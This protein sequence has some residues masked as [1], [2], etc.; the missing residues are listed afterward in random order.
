VYAELHALSNFSFLRGASQPEE[1]IAQ[2][3]ALN[4]SALALTDECTLAGVVRAHVAAKEL[5]LPLIIGTELKCLDKLKLVALATDRASYGAMSRLISKARRATRKGCYA[6][7]RSDL[8]NALA[9]CL[10]IWLPRADK[11]VWQRQEADGRWLRDR[12]AERLW[13]GVELLTGGHD[14]RRL[15][16]LETLGQ[17]LQLPCVAAG[18]VHMHRRSRRALQ[19]VLTAIRIGQ[20]LQAA[21]YALYPNGERSLRSLQRLGELYPAQLLTQTLHIAERCTFKL[22]ELRY[23]YPEEIVPAGETPASHLRA[24]TMQGCA[25]RW[26]AGAPAAVLENIE[27]ELRLIAELNFEPFFLTVHDIVD[28]ARSQKI[29]CQG[30]GSA[31]NS[32][33]CYCL[34]ITEVDPSRMSMLFERFISKERNEPPDIDVDFEHERREEVIQYIYRK[35]GRE[36]AALAATVICYRPRSALRDVGK[37]LGL[38]LAQ[39]D[40]LAQGMQW[41]DGQ[42][43]DPERIRASGFDPDDPVIARLIALTAE[44]LGFPRHLSQHVGGF[45]IARGRLD[46]LVPIENAAMPDRTVIEWDKDDLDALGLLKVDVLALGMLT[47]IRRTFH[48]VNEFGGSSAAAGDLEL[49]SIPSEDQAVYDMICRADTIGVFQIESRAQMS[50][51]PRLKPRNFYDL[52]IEVAIVRP[53]PIQGEM[54]HPYLRRRSGEEEV[55]YPSQEVEAVLKRTLGVP[56]FQE[57]VMQLAIVAAG[58]SPGEAD[59]LRRAMAAWKRKGGLEPFQ[60]QLIDG[61]RER[62][63]SESFA[64]QIF[65]QILGFGEYGFP[66]CVVG[67][68]R[69]V[70]A[71]TGKWVTIDDVISGQARLDNTLACDDKLRLQK[72]K[73]LRVISS[74]VK[75]VRRL[76]T[77]LGHEI[78]ATAE[79]PFMTVTGWLELGKLKVGDHV[80]TARSVPV[81]GHRRWSRH[82]ILVLADLIAEGNL[83]HPSTFYFY[84]TE[85]WHRDDFVEAVE[86]F[87]NTKAVVERHKNCF[88]VR[89]RRIDRKRQIGA[90]TWLRKLGVWGCG[91]RAKR[92]PP[93]V[94]ELRNSNIE[95][96][97][98]RL[99]EGDGGFSVKGGHASYDTAS[100]ILA[101]QVQHLLLRL[102]II[103]RLYRR[104]RAYKG[105]K[106]EHQVITV[107]GDDLR[108]FCCL[109]GRRFLDPKRRRQSK[110]LAAPRNGRMSRDIIPAGVRVAIRSER[111]K[112]KLTW[113]EISRMTG[114]SM[115]EIQGHGVS[116]I[117][118]RRH[119]IACV[120]TALGSVDLSRLACSDIYWD[121][122]VEIEAVGDRE[123]YDLKIEGDHNFLANNFIVHNS[124][125]ASFALLVYTSAWLKHYEPAAFCAAL[126]NSQPMGFYAPAQLVRD[127]RAH[128]VEVRAVDVTISGWDCTLERREDGRPA[129]RL[130]LRLVKHLSQEGAA[131]LLAMRA[132]CNFDGIADMAERAALDRRDLEALAAADALTKLAGHR[133]RAVW[134]VTGVERA[135]PLLPAATAVDEGIPLLRAPREGQDIVADYGSLGL[136]L[137]RHP[138]ALLRDRLQRR[139]VVPTRELWEQPNGKWVKTAGLV[140]TRQRPGSAG[141][142]TFVTMEDETGYVNLIVWN[143]VAVE[144]RAALLESRL[145]EV[146]GKLQRE[147]DVQHV[148][149]QR[150][151]NLSSLLGDLVVGSRNFH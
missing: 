69:V 1:L 33:V 50:M 142:V 129:L 46:E 70:D 123:T 47:A 58:F 82:K 35:Y 143:R 141:G 101:S 133:H 5:G 108:K 97:L 4:Y 105:R 18:D 9:G 44:I 80:A 118:F 27:H 122:V 106:L 34:R 95:L 150:L 139:G 99:W 115:R 55:N 32:T 126:I 29:L 96:L 85:S 68:T 56:I 92:L 147:G 45:V 98:A 81:A 60:H 54:V 42:R 91:A 78:T 25:Y 10:I 90:V 136:T 20:P 144:Q 62:G 23:E 73:V 26:P 63:Y 135:L 71:D 67:E 8:E 15:E 137:R 130:G 3:K 52:V 57:Q 76:R 49:A 66:E 102:G 94:F 83:C 103:S 86:H 132:A 111:D 64:N 88:S 128:G 131:R 117:G 51:L 17:T 77:A 39:V 140:I 11:A 19:D 7:A 112:Q 6:L 89:V 65:N 100:S 13:I 59:R 2:A 109:V 22:D 104:V 93:E 21:G 74:G 119:V 43:I 134:Q 14:T 127:A 84:T 28:Y 38:D 36:R 72:R 114:L 124:H 48:L 53:G 146:H 116:K 41:W 121:K 16:L 125:S 145:L 61:M 37:A 12:F 107:T 138:L 113:N 24:L 75:P 149:A 120:A 148:I 151:T 87:P 31:A 110:L 79:H 40:R 30:R